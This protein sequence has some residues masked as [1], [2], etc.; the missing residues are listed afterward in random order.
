MKLIYTTFAAAVMAAIAAGEV[1]AETINYFG[2]EGTNWMVE[3]IS[4][5]SPEGVV[6]FE[7]LVM[8]NPKTIQGR[9]CM[10]ISSI[11]DIENI[12]IGYIATEGE[13]VY[14]LDNSNDEWHL[15]YDFG[16]APGE[17]TVVSG[18]GGLTSANAAEYHRYVAECV[19]IEPMPGTELE[20]MSLK[21]WPCDINGEIGDAAYEAQWIRG[22]GS[23]NGPCDND[24]FA[25]VGVG[26]MLIEAE[27]DGTT[28]YSRQPYIPIDETFV[29][30]FGREGSEWTIGT[31]GVSLEETDTSYEVMTLG[32]PTVKNYKAAWPVMY[33]KTD[34]QTE[35]T[36]YYVSA[37]MGEVYLAG[38][39]LKWRLIYDFDMQ[40]GDQTIIYG[41]IDISKQEWIP[42]EFYA[43]CVTV[44]AMS[45]NPDLQE[46]KVRLNPT[47]NESGIEVEQRW[48]R[49]VG[50]Y[51]GMLENDFPQVVGVSSVLESLTYD[52]KEIYRKPVPA[53]VTLT[54]S[55]SA[56]DC[57]YDLY[58]R[59]VS[60]STDTL[61]KGIYVVVTDGIARKVMMP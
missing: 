34:G 42:F 60:G 58:G 57:V 1:R 50:S 6:S 10:L 19:S 43:E 35:Q 27:S 30:Y 15:M 51:D 4:D 18:T 38:P 25:W 11:G 52:D 2:I 17:S 14:F 12:P 46:M 54:T 16:L 31:S 53:G 22:L 5:I 7:G 49:S 40:P 61:R 21:M 3:S 29:N 9:D 56:V 23:T 45:D 28:I 32:A 8:E 33:V 39:D 36:G 24:L 47:G 48:I 20:L 41:N 26:S 37:R 55:D 13:R 44:G 59:R